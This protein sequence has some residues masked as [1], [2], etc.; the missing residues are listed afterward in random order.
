MS[1]AETDFK[2]NRAVQY[3]ES[4]ERRHHILEL[5]RRGMN[6]TQIAEALGN[7]KKL[8]EAG[9]DWEPISVSAKTCATVVKRYLNQ[10]ESEEVESRDELRQIENERLDAMM[11]KWL[12]RQ[13]SEDAAE[14]ARAAAV[15]LRV[16][17]RRARL[18]GLDAPTRV[19]VNHSGSIAHELDVNPEEVARAKQSFL[20]AF[21]DADV[22]LD[23]RDIVELPSGDSEDS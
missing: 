18:N 4:T 1:L 6:Y 16:H 23:E 2:A 9:L 15:L 7:K 19:N 20:T 13:D 17:E 10:L 22:T 14:R 8:T 3:L 5:R 21:G 12:P 11:R